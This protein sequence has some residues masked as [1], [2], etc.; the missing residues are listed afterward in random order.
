MNA[1]QSVVR[2]ENEVVRRHVVRWADL[3]ARR[4]HAHDPARQA[5]DRK[6]FL[7]E[8]WDDCPDYPGSVELADEFEAAVNEAHG[9]RKRFTD[10]LG[11]RVVTRAT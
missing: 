3:V 1:V 5:W 9:N 6:R 7:L 11:R 2:V 10:A 8:L 4:I